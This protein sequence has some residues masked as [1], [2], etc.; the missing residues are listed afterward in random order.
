[1]CLKCNKGHGQ[2]SHVTGCHLLPHVRR[3]VLV[4]L[5]AEMDALSLYAPALCSEKSHSQ[6]ELLAS[7]GS[8]TNSVRDNAC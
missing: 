6:I 1:M 8:L 2:S 3:S 4:T 5:G 7:A